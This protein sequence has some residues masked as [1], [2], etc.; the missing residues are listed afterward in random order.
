M[1]TELGSSTAGDMQRGQSL[2]VWAIA[3]GCTL[4]VRST[5]FWR[6]TVPTV[7]GGS[8]VLD[9]RRKCLGTKNLRQKCRKTL[10]AGSRWFLSAQLAAAAM[11]L[12][13]GTSSLAHLASN[14]LRVGRLNGNP[15]LNW[16]DWD[17][18]NRVMHR[19]E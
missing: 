7:G 11:A 8:R 5:V 9:R 2:I 4:R 6:Q 14:L 18:Q 15:G 1:T 10:R 16:D 13:R 3:D 17:W 19:R 12:N